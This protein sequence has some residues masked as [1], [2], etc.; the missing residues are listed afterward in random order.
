MLP[1]HRD[2]AAAFAGPDSPGLQLAMISKID[3]AMKSDKALCMA[4]ARSLD[5]VSPSY[6]TS[7]A[8][9]PARADGKKPYTHI[10]LLYK[11]RN[12]YGDA[13]TVACVV[14][15]A[16]GDDL[17]LDVICAWKPS[18]EYLDQ[19]RLPDPQYGKRMMLATIEYARAQGFRTVSLNA[20]AHVKDLYTRFSF[21]PGPDD[22][23]AADWAPGRVQGSSDGYRFRKCLTDGSPN[24]VSADAVRHRLPA[25]SEGRAHTERT[26]VR[27]I[28]L[29]ADDASSASSS[30]ASSRGARLRRHS[31]SSS[32][33]SVRGGSSSRSPSPLFV[34]LTANSPR[35]AAAARARDARLA[36][37]RAAVVPRR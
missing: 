37:A 21:L 22:P 30:R 9:N 25:L 29:T 8:L 1:V 31:P 14:L 17:F 13:S 4:K 18:K 12:K 24:F 27:A 5:G 34:D 16:S 32:S 35:T 19:R 33:S 23:C 6:M 10:G 36:V 15:A 11:T 3:T 28:D 20:L 2:Y 7:Y 26:S